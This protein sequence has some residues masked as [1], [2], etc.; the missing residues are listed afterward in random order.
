MTT[1]TITPKYAT[2][3]AR[4]KGT[5]AAGEHVAVTVAGG[6][7]WLRDGLTLRVIDLTTRRT[8]AVFPR[9]A[10]VLE[11][12]EA[13]DAWAADGEDL[14][15]T[16][17]LNTDRMVAADTADVLLCCAMLLFSIYS[18][19]GIY[20]DDGT[21]VGRLLPAIDSGL[22]QNQKLNARLAL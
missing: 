14:V 19:K 2:K 22:G 17:N 12:G 21:L 15:C 1:L 13:P 8:L 7:E 18:G 16:L 6:A 4:F 10:E 11:D 5:V 20:L 9:P 3:E